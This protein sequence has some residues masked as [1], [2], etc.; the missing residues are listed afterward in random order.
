LTDFQTRDNQLSEHKNKP[1]TSKNDKNEL[2]N[3][4]KEPNNPTGKKS[5]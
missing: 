5:G 4:K 3:N 1:S 2:E